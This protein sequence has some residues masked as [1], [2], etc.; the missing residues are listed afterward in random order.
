MMHVVWIGP[1]VGDDQEQS[2]TGAG[3][4]GETLKVKIYL[5]LLWTSG[6][7]DWHHRFLAIVK[8]KQGRDRPDTR[9]KVC[10]V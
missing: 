3:T 7:Y 2:A 10:C 8:M 5:T 9:S 1:T 6:F 4:G